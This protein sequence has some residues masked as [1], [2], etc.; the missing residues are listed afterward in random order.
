MSSRAVLGDTLCES[1]LTRHGTAVF[2]SVNASESN[3]AVLAEKNLRLV[4]L[5][6]VSVK[7]FVQKAMAAIWNDMETFKLVEIAGEDKIQA[8]LEGCTRNKAVYEKIARGMV[9]F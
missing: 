4:P 6:L 2:S 7:D 8:L 5:S 1:V 9:E 3:W